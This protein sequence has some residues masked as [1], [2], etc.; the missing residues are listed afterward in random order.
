MDMDLDERI[1]PEADLREA[2]LYEADLRGADLREANLY[3]AD[4]HG[5][6]LDFSCWPLSCKS[7][8]VK[9]GDKIV[10]QLFF[11]WAR[12]DTSQ[13]SAH[14]RYMHRFIV[15]TFGKSM[16]NWFCKFREDVDRI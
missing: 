6:N 4:L 3:G 7:L 8:G 9:V 16:A 11:H 12:I 2:D 1:K 5:A 15:N 13:C 14:I 10:A